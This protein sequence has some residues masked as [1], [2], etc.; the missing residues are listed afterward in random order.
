MSLILSGSDGL[1]DIDGSAATPAIRGTDA[2]TGIFFPAVDTI[3][4]STAGTEDARF[5]SSGRLGLGTTA[6]DFK[7]TVT[8]AAGTNDIASF[9]ASASG[10]VLRMSQTS[11]NPLIMRMVNNSNN[12]WDTQVNV[13]NSIS[14]DYND[15]ERARI[16]SSGVFLIGGTTAGAVG[17]VSIY[18]FGSGSSG[19]IAFT[20]TADGVTNSAFAFIAGASVVGT[21]TYNNTTTA[22]NNLSDYRL[23]QDIQPMTGALSKVALLKPCTYKWSVD[24]SDGQGF[25][26]H[27]LQAV[28]PDAVTGEKDAVD[29]DGNPKYQ[30]IDV[31]FLVA[32]LTA[33]LQEQQALIETLKARLDAANL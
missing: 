22:Y 25:I 26:A 9:S 23:K 10:Q 31:S 21:I 12:F 5:D 16:L 29:A 17:A 18:P 30:G 15:T 6:P 13:D 20:K 3:A 1:S 24:G 14:W 27:E 33:A 2:N 32:T 4:F 8:G 28:V 19:Q 11:A 7:L